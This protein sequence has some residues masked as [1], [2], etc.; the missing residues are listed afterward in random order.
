M[1]RRSS[2]LMPLAI[3]NRLHPPLLD[4]RTSG[5]LWTDRKATWGPYSGPWAT[6]ALAS[7]AL[8]NYEVRNVKKA[9]LPVAAATALVSCSLPPLCSRCGHR[10]L[11][12]PKWVARWRVSPQPR[13]VRADPCRSSGVISGMP[14]S[15]R[16]LGGAQGHTPAARGKQTALRQLWLTF[17]GTTPTQAC[18]KWNENNLSVRETFSWEACWSS[19][20]DRA[21]VFYTCIWKVC[22]A[23]DCCLKI[24]IFL[25]P[26]ALRVNYHDY[27]YFWLLSNV[28][29]SFSTFQ[30]EILVSKMSVLSCVF[31]GDNCLYN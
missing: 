27:F 25:K 14:D 24:C 13:P 3:K 6:S 12:L 5:A 1:A 8:L 29:F 22:V 9:T 30:N 2:T 10:T 20:Q 18:P 28:W 19:G 15:C 23:K 26:N 17:G 16:L 21:C 31:I 4:T 11:K 7:C